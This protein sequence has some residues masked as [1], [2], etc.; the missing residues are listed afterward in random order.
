[1]WNFGEIQI[2]VSGFG[3]GGGRNFCARVGV[4]SAR[5]LDTNPR[6]VFTDSPPFMASDAFTLNP[7]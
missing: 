1:L 2:P 5:S 7:V 3:R 4:N 6:D